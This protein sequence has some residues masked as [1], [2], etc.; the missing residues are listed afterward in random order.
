MSKV[1]AR[2]AGIYLRQSVTRGD[3]VSLAVQEERCRAWCEDNGLQVVAVDSD[4]DTSGSATSPWRRPGFKR[5]MEQDWDVLVVY[6]QDRLVRDFLKFWKVVGDLLERG[7]TLASATE[8][9]DLSTPMGKSIAGVNA[10]MA[11]QAAQEISQRVADARR[12][13]QHR[14]RV[15]GGKVP[16]G[17]KS[18]PNPAG[19]G[20]VLARDPERI[21][22][23][24]TMVDRTL[25]GL[26]VY[27]TVQHLNE[28]GVPSPT[29]R[30]PWVYSSVERLL[31]HP[32]LAGMTP[33]N[34]GNGGKKRGDDVLRDESGLPVV[35]ERLAI[36]TVADWRRMLAML[37]DDESGRRKPR[38]LRSSTSALLS[39]VVMC[40]EHAEPVRMW[41]GTTQGRP[42]YRCPECSQTISGLDDLVVSEFLREKG[43]RLRWRRV[44][45]ITEGGAAALPEIDRRLDELAGLIRAAKGAERAALLGQQ[46]ALLD[47]RDEAE[48]EAP[49]VEYVSE[50]GDQSFAE[51]WAEAADVVA[52]RAVLDDGLA[53]VLVRRGGV[54]R[55]TREQ[56]LERLT[57][58]WIGPTGPEPVPDETWVLLEA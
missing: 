9:L 33:F 14:G 57:F 20:L 24:R 43:D 8:N 1:R 13:L 3:T 40:A 49:T 16:M 54:G 18:V 28:T 5:L 50:G 23:V 37:D 6:K 27:S 29:G 47:R 56:M 17:W 2:R 25:A 46:A 48:D 38:A 12:H 55:R 4:P 10:G 7:R 32:I 11:E 31:R 34:P 39:G 58:Q 44:E 19:P 53:G 41:R 35:D 30:G 15:V 36:M 52:Q 42:S 26:S 21:G 22:V 45:V 51:D